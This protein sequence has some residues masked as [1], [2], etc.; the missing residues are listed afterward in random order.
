MQAS[1]CVAERGAIHKERHT[2]EAYRHE[3]VMG[4]GLVKHRGVMYWADIF[5]NKLVCKRNHWEWCSEYVIY[6]RDVYFGLKVGSH[7]CILPRTPIH[8]WVEIISICPN[9]TAILRTKAARIDIN[10]ELF[11][12]CSRDKP[13]WTIALDLWA[14]H[15]VRCVWKSEFLWQSNGARSKGVRRNLPW[16]L[17]N[18]AVA[19]ER[20]DELRKNNINLYMRIKSIYIYICVCIYMQIRFRDLCH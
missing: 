16:A 20:R 6:M 19:Q 15:K 12:L 3:P 5:M 10:P 14:Q 17:H 4:Q 2:T 9:V 18:V 1:E 8:S 11:P 13:C 7:S